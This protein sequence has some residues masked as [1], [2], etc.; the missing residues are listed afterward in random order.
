MPV[1]TLGL[2]GGGFGGGPTSM[3]ERNECQ[4]GCWAREG[5]GLR[6][7]T[8]VGEE[9]KPPFIRVWKPFPSRRVLKP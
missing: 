8:L 9:N 2:K 7:P 4:R 6:C 1:R 3:G 5:G